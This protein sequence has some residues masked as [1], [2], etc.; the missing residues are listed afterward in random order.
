MKPKVYIAKPIPLEV[1]EYI[2]QSCEYKIWDKKEAIPQ[3]VLYEEIADVDGLMIS[4]WKV[5]EEFLDHAPKLKILSN[6]AAGYENF[7]YE[8][9]KKR[10]VLGTNTPHVLDDSVADLA[11]GLILMT[12]RKL[13]R[14]NQ[15]VKD[16]SWSRLDDEDFL[17]QDVHHATLGIIGMGNIG[18]KIAKRAALGFDMHVLYNN[19]SKRP[20]AEE[21]YGAVYAELDDLLRK[22]DF[23]LVMLPLSTATE[24]LIGKRE[25]D[26]MKPSS[27]FFNCSRGKIVKEAELIEALQTGSIKGAGLDVYETEPVDKDNPLLKMDNVVTMPHMGSAT[28]A[29]RFK[30]AMT[31]AHNLVAGVTGQNPPNLVKE[32]KDMAKQK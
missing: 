15:Y 12:A 20:D 4:K 29:T 11:L 23:V 6:V 8:L 22:A 21:K 28:E 18:E 32:L 14:L 13:G 24:G 17:G 27:F 2:A 26:L 1:E 9:M 10:N 3:D 30:M 31:A 16:G 7:D 19:R 5:S 25:F